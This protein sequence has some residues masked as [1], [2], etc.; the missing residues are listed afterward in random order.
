MIGFKS[1][2]TMAMATSQ[3]IT[4]HPLSHDIQ[5]RQVEAAVVPV[6]DPVVVDGGGVYMRTTT[7]ADG[8]ILGGY[9]SFDGP[10]T[11]L[12]V[13]KSTDGGASW[14]VIGSVDSGPSE[15]REI[16]NA[17]P[18]A[19]PDGRI[20]YA[21]RNHDKVPGGG[22]QHYRITLC[23]SEDG[24][25][26][27]SFLSHIDE[28]ALNGRNGL[29]E[30]FLRIARDGAIQAFYSAENS[31]SD[32]DNIMR[33]STDGGRTW[34]G[35]YGMSGGDVNSRDGMIGIANIDNDSNLM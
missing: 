34:S 26:S 15:S 33:A 21:F 19:L 20:L 9:T 11:I 16:D 4:A 12:R 13:T 8:S 30:P 29:W 17:F 7:L 1:I 23:V 22:Y 25:V 6:A 2:F 5:D 24:G 32:Q 31:D 14:S 27:W 35:I 10:T 3:L 18:L 28:R